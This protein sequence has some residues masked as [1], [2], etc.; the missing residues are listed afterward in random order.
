[1]S[2]SNHPLASPLGFEAVDDDE[3]SMLPL[4][5]MPLVEDEDVTNASGEM[6]KLLVLSNGCSALMVFC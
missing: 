1:M 6:G 4:I 2:L 5:D 3:N